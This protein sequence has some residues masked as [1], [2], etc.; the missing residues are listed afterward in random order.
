MACLQS[1]PLCINPDLQEADGIMSGTQHH[2]KTRRTPARTLVA[3]AVTMAIAQTALAQVAT[4]EPAV[5]P[6]IVVTGQAASTRNALDVQQA[7][8]NVV[9]AVKSD[10]IGQ[11]PDKNA[12]EALQRLPG[13]SVERDQGEGRYVRIRG[14]GPDFNTVTFNGSLVPAPESDRRAVALDVLPSAL[15]RSIEVSKTLTPDMDANSLGGT[16]NVTTLSA[17]DHKGPFLSLETGMHFDTNTKRTGPNASLVWSDLFL[18]GKLGIAAGFSH[19]VRKFGS[20]NVEA[21]DWTE[22]GRLIDMERRD[23]R[24]TRE[25]TGLALNLE[26]RPQKGES[27]YVRTLHTRFSDDEIRQAHKIEGVE[28]S[29][30]DPIPLSDGVAGE[31][32]SSRRLKARKETQKVTSVT[33]GLERQLGEWAINTALGLSRASEDTPLHISNAEFEADDSLTGVGFNGTRKPVLFGNTSIN[34]A[35]QYTFKEGELSATKAT[36][37]EAN[38]RLDLSRKL[39]ILGHKTAI[40]L[41]GKLSHRKKTSNED[42]WLLERDDLSASDSALSLS[43]FSSGAVDYAWGTFGPAI[44]AKL[45]RDLIGDQAQV[46]DADSRIND[47]EMRERIAAAYAMSTTTF[48]NWR[49]MSGLRWEGTRFNA[50]GTGDQDGTFERVAAK[51]KYNDWLPALHLRHELDDDTSIRVALTKS[52]VRPTFGQLAPGFQVDGDEAE[53]GNPDLKPLRSNNLDVGFERRLDDASAMSAYAFVKDI[54]NFAYRTNVAGTGSWTAFDEAITYRNGERSRLYGIEL[55]Y[56]H[57]FK[58]LPAPW[59]GLLASANLTLTHSSAKISEFDPDSGEVV[60]RNIQLPSQ[61]DQAVNLSLGYEDPNWSFRLAANHKSDYLY[62]V[63]DVRDQS[64]DLHVQAQTQFDFSAAYRISKQVQVVFE[65]V[66]INN[67]HYYVYQGTPSRN[68]QY[69]SYGPSYRLG[70][71]AVLF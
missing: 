52:V 24:I 21:G 30:D 14:L 60:S 23:Y 58:S 31:V 51:Q 50:E 8:H 11:L 40:K 19:D 70:I 47:Y 39:D 55:A 62:E 25:R 34:D 13:V 65:A 3:T 41:G 2:L 9:S 5:L 44:Q 53:F 17:F 59:N 20:D 37:K 66:N 33:L 43:N 38:L 36:D 18:N 22:D 48:G 69:E 15:I 56:T 1:A 49:V 45:V 57:A 4:Q 63:R 61:S 27:Y 12:A 35:T 32:E 46:L 10:D 71:R 28:D 54:S 26:Y 6:T 64:L 16:V 7:A 68:A 67:S 42:A 29:N